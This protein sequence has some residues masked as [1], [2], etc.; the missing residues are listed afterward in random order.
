[1]SGVNLE[2]V[3][4]RMRNQKDRGS[5]FWKNG[6]DK[7]KTWVMSDYLESELFFG[8]GMQLVRAMWF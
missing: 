1:M 2:P 8:D 6:G 7:G 5:L 4:D 3:P